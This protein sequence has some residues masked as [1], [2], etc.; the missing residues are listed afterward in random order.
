MNTCALDS[1]EE[2]CLTK[3]CVNTGKILLRNNIEFSQTRYKTFNC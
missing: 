3:D 1:Q 2:I